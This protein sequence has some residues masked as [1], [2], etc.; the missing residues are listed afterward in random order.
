MAK[1]HLNKLFIGDYP[2]TQYYGER[3]DYY[4]Q[5]GLAGHEGIDYG[6]PV[7]VQITA[8]FDGEILRDVDLPGDKDYGDFLVVWDPVQHCAVWFCHLSVNYFS[9]DQK[10]SKGQVLGLTGN[11][12]N[13]T[14]PHLHISFTEGDADKNRLNKDNGFQG[15]LNILDPNLVQW[16]TG[17]SSTP[18]APEEDMI[19]DQTKLDIPA[20]FGTMEFQAVKSTLLD[21]KN[22]ITSLT[23]QR[24][25]YQK[26][27]NMQASR[28]S[29]LTSQNAMLT[30][31]VKD[32][33]STGVTTADASFLKSFKTWILS[34]FAQKPS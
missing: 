15:F 32:A 24:D 20:P 19:T 16:D 27:N 9:L 8:P 4:K 31:A 34:F 2:I 6:T 25:D 21:Q 10:V 29:D 18:T 26:T 14:G 17:V 22:Q 13:T 28:I 7:G 3:P 11:T 5:F 30:Q 1:Y 33:Q 23:G 12:G